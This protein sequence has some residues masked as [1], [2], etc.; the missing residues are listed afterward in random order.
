MLCGVSSNFALGS[1][2]TEAGFIFH[3][4][5]FD[6]KKAIQVWWKTVKGLGE[7]SFSISAITLLSDSNTCI[8]IVTLV[9]GCIDFKVLCF[10]GQ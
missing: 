9:P 6:L 8:T 7:M 2:P 4:S 1:N 5:G 10:L 3:F